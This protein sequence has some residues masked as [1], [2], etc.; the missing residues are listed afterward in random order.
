MVL[1]A[2]ETSQA[3]WLRESGVTVEVQD[4][5]V[6]NRHLPRRFRY[7]LAEAGRYL[8]RWWPAARDQWECWTH[9]GMYRAVLQLVRRQR[10]D[11]L[12][13]NNQVVRHY[14]AI[15]A[16]QKLGLACVSHLR[17]FSDWGMNQHLARV[18]NHHVRLFVAHSAST[19]RMWSDLGLDE[20]KIVVVPN[21]IE[22]SP[23]KPLDV[24]RCLQIP[25][26]ADPL[27]G[28]VG[29]LIPNR[30]VDLLIRAWPLV[31]RRLTRA[32]LVIVGDGEPGLRGGLRQL[33][34]RLGVAESV[35]FRPRHPEGARI[36]AGLDVLA[37]P[38]RT[39][40]FGRVV[41]EAWL[42]G[43]PVVASRVGHIEDYATDGSDIL[44]AGYEDEAGLAEAVL[45][46]ADPIA[47]RPLIR[48]GRH[49]VETRYSAPAHAEAVMALYDRVL[50]SHPGQPNEIAT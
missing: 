47:A 14:F 30:R 28:L 4:D 37:L 18:A 16:G 3:R 45:R 13:L 46:A 7:G 25:G 31:R 1:T 32:G 11:L 19:K 9:R 43:T 40:P 6:Y 20:T 36:I 15:L 10:V 21:G 24:R 33:A 29:H 8:G 17:S 2:I 41:L 26:E 34:R 35:Y 39:E 22:I 38:Y 42:G 44:L 48:A 49:T 12:H 23:V 27:V 5:L 50:N